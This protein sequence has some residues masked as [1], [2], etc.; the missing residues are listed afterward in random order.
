MPGVLELEIQEYYDNPIADL[1]QVIKQDDDEYH[2]VIGKSEV[3]QGEEV[4]YRIADEDFQEGFEWSILDNDR[5]K[6]LDVY[7][8]GKTC[9]VKVHDGAIGTYKVRCGNHLLG[10]TA[11]TTI[12][13]KRQTIKGP[14]EVR[15]YDIVT[16]HSDTP[17]LFSVSDTHLVKIK[18]NDINDC[19]LE[20]VSGKSGQFTIYHMAQD[21]KQSSLIVDIVSM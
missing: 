16:Y 20:I 9:K 6:I 8:G 19:V 10:Y 18:S 12:R 3:W 7:D 1:P 17:G 14:H 21:G 4:G 5:V 13:S 11:T 2:N 15:P